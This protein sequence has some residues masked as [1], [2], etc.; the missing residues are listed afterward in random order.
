MKLLKDF[1]Q[2]AGTSVSHRFDATAYLIRDEKGYFLIDC[3][4]PEGYAQIVENVRS[5]C[6]DPAGI[7]TILATHGHYD[8]VGA[9]NLWRNNFG[10]RLL[11]HELDR[12]QVER[13]D[14]ERTS[15]S[16]LYGVE[17]EP[18]VVDGVLA[19]GDVFPVAGG[20]LEVM[21]T[22]GHTRGSVSFV[23]TRGGES[24]LIAGDAIWGGFSRKIGSDEQLWRES[25]NRIVAR[26]YDYYTFGHIGPQLLADADRR[27]LDAKKQ[28][29][30]YYNPWFRR[31][32]EHYRY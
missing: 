15:A 23:L 31:F 14:S 13:G 20:T 5:L 11:I 29:A 26:H 30:N 7:H 18:T 6:I 3:G 1:Y 9:A 32:D 17:A 21:H 28:F 10:C 19:D 27:L 25:L 8:H 12:E 2:V 24:V 4:T 22:P 16:L